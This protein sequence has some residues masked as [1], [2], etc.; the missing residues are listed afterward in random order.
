MNDK[1]TCEL[2]KREI[3]YITRNDE[4][5]PKRFE[6]LD[7]M[8]EG[9]Y[10]IGELPDDDVPSVGIIGARNCSG[11]GR[12]MAREFAREIAGAGIQ[13]ISGMAGGV[14]GI[15]QSA[16]VAAGG[17]SFGILGG[18]VDICY[19]A[20]NESLY[21]KLMDNGGLISEYPPGTPPIGRNF[22]LRNRIISALSDALLVIEAR[23]RSGT[24]ITV[25]Y[26]LQQGKDVYALPGRVTDSLSYGCNSL[27]ADGA[28]PLLRPY[29]FVNE[30]LDRFAKAK[31]G[32]REVQKVR[33]GGNGFAK[34]GKKEKQKTDDNRL[35]FLSAKE[36]LIVS[37]LDYKPKTVSEI[38]YDISDRSDMGIPELMGLL[39]NMTV[40]HI[41]DC[42][43]GCNYLLPS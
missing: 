42:V 41:I 5:Y 1:I 3:N 19:P 36:R 33:T 30:F 28:Y 35:E 8:P 15:S 39:T 7:N 18:G 12:Q 32:Y 4:R 31:N 34:G 27:I 20:A 43:D 11:Y 24:L 26:A 10:C 13:V 14:D 29:E 2:I 23:E 6:G 25:G 38:L 9:L 40:K 21:E 17:R 37:V 16:A 22:A